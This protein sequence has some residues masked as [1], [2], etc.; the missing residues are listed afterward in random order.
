[1]W[2]KGAASPSLKNFIRINFDG[3]K[4]IIKGGRVCMYPKHADSFSMQI[5][6]EIFDII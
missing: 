4:N 1:M 2:T 6:L 3:E 5:F